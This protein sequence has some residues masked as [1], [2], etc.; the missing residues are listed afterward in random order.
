MPTINSFAP[1]RCIRDGDD[2]HLKGKI[3]WLALNDP[4]HTTIA[5]ILCRRV[6]DVPGKA[7]CRD[8][9]TSNHIQYCNYTKIITKLKREKQK[10]EEC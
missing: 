6:Y 8:Y 7:T 9:L 10:D 4:R 3:M 1:L 5:P 2:P